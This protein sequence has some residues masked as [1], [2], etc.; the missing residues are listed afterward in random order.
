MFN[1]PRKPRTELEHLGRASAEYYGSVN[2]PIYR[3]STALFPDLA[4]FRAQSQRMTYGRRATPSSQALAQIMTAI[5]GG[6]ECFLTPSGLSAVTCAILACV[7]AGGHILISDSV[8][9]P[10]RHFC[11]AILPRLV[12][13]VSYYDPIDL[14]AL[15][16]VIRPE[17]D[18]IFTE[19]PGSLTF[20]VQDIPKIAALAH[21][22]GARVILD[23]SWA[24][25]LFFKPFAHGVDISIQAATKYLCGHADLLLGTICVNEAARKDVQQTHR[26]LG[27]CASGDD[28][29]LTL[30]GLRTLDVRLERHQKT[31]LTIAEFLLEREEIAEVIHPALPSH[32]QHALWQRDFLGASGLFAAR[33][34]P[35]SEAQLAAM[36]DGFELFAMGYSWGG[37]ESLI[38]P[39]DPIR[40][41][42]AYD[43]TQPLIR[44]HAGLE[45]EDD[46]IEDLK[47]GLERL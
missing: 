39:A 45:D 33:L 19:S 15:S 47:A 26:R 13:A 2:V 37:F 8:Y 14:D 43:N 7:K 6:V 23:N 17:T 41:A 46:L 21:Q 32:P 20:E 24:T 22:H 27:L 28:I 4:S 18:V 5:E 16:A 36:F 44:I 12:V 29:Y 31:A 9:E 10:T 30:R 11:D 34:K 25:P 35:C 40:T 1:K 38:I 3:A 42:A